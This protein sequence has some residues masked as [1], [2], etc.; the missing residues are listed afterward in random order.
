MRKRGGDQPACAVPIGD[1]ARVGDR[2][3]AGFDD[4]GD[5][6]FSRMGRCRAF[7]RHLAAEIVDDDRGTFG[8][9]R[10][11]MGVADAAPRAG[12]DRDLSVELTHHTTSAARRRGMTSCPNK[13]CM[14]PS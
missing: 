7:S 13:S 2:L 3:P 11:R 14:C 8:R 5:D 1:V 12:D 6:L 4:R 9:E 10:E